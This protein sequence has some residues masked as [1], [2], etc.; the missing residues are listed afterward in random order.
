MYQANDK[1]WKRKPLSK[2]EKRSRQTDHLEKWLVPKNAIASLNVLM[3]EE[4]LQYQVTKSE[5][6][7]TA[8]LVV[9]GITY[10]GKGEFVNL[11]LFRRRK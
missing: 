9:N 7:Y 10:M 4:K 11:M 1:R 6:G 3:N 2:G 8:E 5:D